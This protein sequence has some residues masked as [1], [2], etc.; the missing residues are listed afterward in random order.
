MAK[1]KITRVDGSIGEYEITPIIQYAFEM[2]AKKG[3][4]KAFVEDAK[5]SDIYFL[6]HE[7]IKRSGET[8]K[9]YG[10]GFIETL[11]SVEVLDSDS[12]LG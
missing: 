4:Y 2:Y 8:I 12:N 5:Q 10:E 7:C 6:A 9:P 11:V 1:L 3:F